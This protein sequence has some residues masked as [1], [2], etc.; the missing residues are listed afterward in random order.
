MTNLPTRAFSYD[1]PRHDGLD[2]IYSDDHILVVNK[3]T[4]LLSVAG[5]QPG[6]D[7][8]LESRA[9]N[10]FP[11]ATMVHRLDLPTSGVI[12]IALNR[13]AHAH[14]GLQFEKR[15][16]RKY[17]VAR[18]HGQPVDEAGVIDLPLATDWP[19]RPRQ[20][21]DHER[22]RSAQTE[23]KVIERESAATRVGLVPHTG[24]SHQLRVH[25]LTLGH[26][27]LGDALYAPEP[28][29][30]AADRL[31]LHAERLEFEHPVDGD[32]RVFEAPC[33]F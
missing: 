7:D 8:C 1:P 24:R 6:M 15:R 18:V 32:Q 12:V 3:P 11:G 13:A 17:Y 25:M 5:A 31:Q 10:D 19:N 16:T 27:I 22:G 4:G 26:P 2:V 9:A 29:Y 28:A 14:I 33:P 20:Q 30:R 23:W 21:V